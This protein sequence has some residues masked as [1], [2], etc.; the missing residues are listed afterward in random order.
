ML[1][2]GSAILRGESDCHREEGPPHRPGAS[3]HQLRPLK[4]GPVSGIPAPVGPHPAAEQASYQAWRT[5]PGLKVWNSVPPSVGPRGK[6]PYPE[7]SNAQPLSTW[8]HRYASRPISS[9]RE[10]PWPQ[11][12]PNGL[13]QKPAVQSQTGEYWGT[14]VN[15][16][17]KEKTAPP[18][19]LP[20]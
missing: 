5:S 6:R 12:Q 2:R 17:K 1:N 16:H 9:P 18:G 15:G 10:D 19:S 4:S 7:Q 8:G 14:F 11:S 20:F 3:S 13:T